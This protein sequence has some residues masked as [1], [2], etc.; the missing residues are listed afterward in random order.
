MNIE[1]NSPALGD[2]RTAHEF[3]EEAD[4]VRGTFTEILHSQIPEFYQVFKNTT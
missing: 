4:N 2:S 1:V 3:P